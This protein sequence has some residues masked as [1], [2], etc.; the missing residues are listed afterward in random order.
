MIIFERLRFGLDSLNLMEISCPSCDE[1][2]LIADEN[3]GENLERPL[4]QQFIEFEE[5]ES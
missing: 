1:A 5:P 2:V 4:C 3:I